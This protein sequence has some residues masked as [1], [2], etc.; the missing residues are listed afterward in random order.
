MSITEK[1]SF[2]EAARIAW[3]K[4]P[5]DW[6][7]VLAEAC[8][9]SGQSATALQIGMSVS[10]VN[11]TLRNKYKGRRENVRDRVMGALMGITV[12]CPVLGDDL[13]RDRCLDLQGRPFAATNPERVQLFRRCPSCPNYRGQR[14]AAPS[15]KPE[16]SDQ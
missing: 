4:A 13:P 10:V 5:P 14:K 12:D 3:D 2:S 15:S 11:E 9:R 6:I 1:M 8:D 16:E 7:V